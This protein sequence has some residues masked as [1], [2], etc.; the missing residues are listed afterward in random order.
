MPG[1][2]EERLCDAWIGRPGRAGDFSRIE[3]L[4]TRIALA[5]ERDSGAALGGGCG[6]NA[7]AAVG[8]L[9]GASAGKRDKPARGDCPQAGR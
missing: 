2:D 6:R 3:Y 4:H 7:G 5:G 1:K 9:L 8:G